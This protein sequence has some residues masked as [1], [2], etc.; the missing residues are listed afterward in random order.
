VGFDVACYLIRCKL[1]GQASVASE[2]DDLAAARTIASLSEELEDAG[3]LEELRQLE[4]TAAN[5]YWHAW[6][7]VEVSF[8]RRDDAKVPACWRRFE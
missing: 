5:L 6:E 1:A 8:V 4:S 3:S 2:L 7:A